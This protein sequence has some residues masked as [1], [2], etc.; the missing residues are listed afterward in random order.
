MT[1]KQS[2]TAPNKKGLKTERQKRLST[3]LRENL[4]KRKTQSQERQKSK[5]EVEPMV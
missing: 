3:A 5:T 2:E 1:T 4:R